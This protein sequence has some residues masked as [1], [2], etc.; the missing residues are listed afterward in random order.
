MGWERGKERALRENQR[1]P[2][3]KVK[4]SM[5]KVWQ[6]AEHTCQSISL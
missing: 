6:R 4:S 1:L 5:S 3:S 2:E